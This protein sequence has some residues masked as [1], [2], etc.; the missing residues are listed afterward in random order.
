M[1]ASVEA[2]VPLLDHKLV[3]FA[4]ALPPRLKVSGLTRKYLLKEASRRWLPAAIV[5][6][7]KEG[8]PTPLSLWLRTEARPLVRDLLSPATLRSRGLFDHR[9]VDGLVDE[10]ERGFADH[11]H[12]LWGLLSVEIWQRLFL[13]RAP[14]LEPPV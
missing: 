2:R 3:E 13:D 9:Y 1:A 4:A 5:D 6:R 10:H 11:G 14:S 12:L 7:K 8:F